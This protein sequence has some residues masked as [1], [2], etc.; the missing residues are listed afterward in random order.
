M[1]RDSSAVLAYFCRSIVALD[2]RVV[3]CWRRFEI[4]DSLRLAVVGWTVAQCWRRLSTRENA[5]PQWQVNGLRPVCFLRERGW[6]RPRQR[7][8]QSGSVAR[9]RTRDAPDV[10]RQV[11]R[12]RE[13]HRAR[14]EARALVDLGPDLGRDV[15]RRRLGLGLAFALALTGSG[16]G[17]LVRARA[18]GRRR[19]RR[20]DAGLVGGLLA[21]AARGSRAGARE[22]RRA[23]VR[24]RTLAAGLGGRRRQRGRDDG[25]SAGW[26]VASGVA[27]WRRRV[28]GSNSDGLGRDDGRA[29]GSRRLRWGCQADA[30]AGGCSGRALLAAEG[31]G[32][33]QVVVR[34]GRSAVRRGEARRAGRLDA[35]RLRGRERAAEGRHL[36]HG[37]GQ[38]A[39]TRA[40][41][42]GKGGKGASE[43]EAGSRRCEGVRVR[44][45]SARAHDACSDSP[46]VRPSVVVLI[47]AA[48]QGQ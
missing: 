27:S 14:P 17:R 22:G 25:G 13:D 28:G 41:R 7:R 38:A 23:L 30:R 18:R 45:P 3:C 36:R 39:G 35:A 31:G 40:G 19:R 2:V 11:L 12:P 34:G 33:R 47:T 16:R 1:P 10:P 21:A 5:L 4:V 26:R 20:R 8:D 44:V 48:M 24:P 29:L 9:E 42:R 46:L 43:H 32:R 6:C 15:V 37:R